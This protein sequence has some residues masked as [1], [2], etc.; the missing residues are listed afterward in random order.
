MSSTVRSLGA[1]RA[2]VWVIKHIVS[3]L[4]RRLYGLTNGRFLSSGRPLAPTLLLT[5]TGRK[6]GQPRTVGMRV[7]VWFYRV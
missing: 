1:T 6:S 3:P 5:T 4:D 7:C 2:G